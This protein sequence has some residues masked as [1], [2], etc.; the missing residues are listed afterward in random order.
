MIIFLF[1][2]ISAQSSGHYSDAITDNHNLQLLKENELQHQLNISQLHISSSAGN[3]SSTFQM[4]NIIQT[5][6]SKS[7]LPLS[8]KVNGNINSTISDS[9]T[10]ANK[11]IILTFGDGYQ[12][13]YT[14]AK[15][16]L[17]EYGYKG[18]FFVTCNKIGSANKMTW[19]E[20]VQLYKE[21]NVI[22]SKTVDYGTKA[23]E[24]KDLNHLSAQQL[25]FEVG[26]SKQCLIN[27]GIKTDYFAVPMNLANN[28]ST[29][30]NTIAKYYTLAING[31]ADQIY[32][33]CDGYKKNSSQTDCRTYFDNGTLTFANRYS[34]GE[35]SEQHI[36]N[37]RSYNDSQMFAKFITVVN[38]Q[39]KFNKNGVTSIPLIAY[40]DIVM[41]SDISLSNEPSATT[42]NLFNG[43]MK[44]LH[45]NGF[46]VLTFYN[47]GYD[48]KNNVFQLNYDR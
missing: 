32:L 44:Y 16:I 26:Q 36:K 12:S 43:E 21:G 6:P 29:V 28:N 11:V 24:G 27:H 35:W 7:P 41:L 39:N 19:A 25:E 38:S 5:L 10:N 45:D 8:S 9:S 2:D 15:P 37:G 17:D 18:N 22:G 14:I 23:M 42:L 4:P 31:H 46:R 20:L 40:H 30:I 33:H 13:Q 48:N 47:L 1:V 3:L 34:I